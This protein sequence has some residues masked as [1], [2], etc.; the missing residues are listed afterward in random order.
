MSDDV[1]A[2]NYAGA[3]TGRRAQIFP[4]LSQEQC[5]VVLRYG[6]WRSFP[7]GAVLFRQG[8][9]H[10]SMYVV[11][12]GTVEVSR[13][14]A[15]QERVVGVHGGRTF[16]GDIGTIAGRASIA[17]GRAVTDCEVIEVDEAALRI[18]VVSEADLS[19]LIMRAY[20]LRRVGFINDEH[21]GVMLIGSRQS[22]D[23]L[24][25]RDFLMRNS[26]P[27][28]Y[29]DVDEHSESTELMIRFGISAEQI[30]AVITPDGAV[31]VQPQIGPL[32]T[33]SA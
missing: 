2:G 27:V 21:G 23:T 25:L 18:L 19:E 9:R 15:M 5:D 22:A 4:E 8:E 32:L 11:V 1:Q 16:T 24:R 3:L 31:L 17:T 14:S 10:I 13:G 33:Q 6:T 30:P 7:A 20:I 26:Q 12:S 28:A 29:F